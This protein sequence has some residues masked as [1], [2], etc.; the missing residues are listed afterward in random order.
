MLHSLDLAFL[1]S[2]RIS[3]HQARMGRAELASLHSKGMPHGAIAP[4][5]VVLHSLS[6]TL[7]FPPL[8]PRIHIYVELPTF[9]TES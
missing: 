4:N 9:P 3:E 2:L 5:Q 6:L 1:Y 8:P 7:I